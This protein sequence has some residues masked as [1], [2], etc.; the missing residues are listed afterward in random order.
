MTHEP[1]VLAKVRKILA[2]AEDPAATPEEAETYTAKAAELMAA[3]GIDRALLAESM[4][5][6]DVVGD[7]VVVLDAPYALDKAA[8]LSSVAFELRCRA[9]RRIRYVGPRATKEVSIHLFGYDSDLVRVEILFTSLLLQAQTSLAR[10]DPPPW[11]SPAAYRRSW[12]AGFTA[13]VA[14][15]LRDAEMRARDVAEESRAGTAAPSGRSVELVLVDRDRT[16]A[17]AVEAE[18]PRLGTARS[19]QLSGSGRRSGWQAGQRADLGGS[20]VPSGRRGELAG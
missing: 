4:P 12:L 8:L 16:V 5:D 14:R 3:Y 13:A 1:D 11:E 20:R 2:K 6:S 10:T 17:A 15:R 9:V 19:R 7:R 18:Y